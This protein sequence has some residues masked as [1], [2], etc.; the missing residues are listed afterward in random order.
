MFILFIIYENFFLILQSWL[1]FLCELYLF[2]FEII[3]LFFC[4]ITAIIVLMLNDVHFILKFLYCFFVIIQPCSYCFCQGTFFI[5]EPFSYFTTNNFTFMYIDIW[6]LII[7]RFFLLQN[8]CY[9]FYEKW[10]FFCSVF[11]SSFLLLFYNL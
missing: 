2:W 9:C 10:H 11:I 3:L 8:D 5:F 6:F 1:A 7:L 4:Y